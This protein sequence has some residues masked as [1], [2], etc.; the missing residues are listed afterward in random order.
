MTDNARVAQPSI[1]NLEVCG[2]ILKASEIPRYPL[3]KEAIFAPEDIFKRGMLAAAEG[4]GQMTEAVHSL[5][6]Q[7]SLGGWETDMD[8]D[9]VLKKRFA[10]RFQNLGCL[11]QGKEHGFTVVTAVVRAWRSSGNLLLTLSTSTPCG[12]HLNRE[13]NKPQGRGG[14]FTGERSSLMMVTWAIFHFIITSLLRP[15][16]DYIIIGEMTRLQPGPRSFMANLWGCYLY[17]VSSLM[18]TE[19]SETL[20]HLDRHRILICN[21]CLDNSTMVGRRLPTLDIIP[22]GWKPSPLWDGYFDSP[23]QTCCGSAGSIHQFRVGQW[24]IK[25]Q[26]GSWRTIVDWWSRQGIYILMMKGWSVTQAYDNPLL[27]KVRWLWEVHDDIKMLVR[28]PTVDLRDRLMGLTA[29]FT[30]LDGEISPQSRF[31]MQGE[32]IDLHL[33]LP[34]IRLV[35]QGY[36]DRHV[37]RAI[38]G[39]G[40][41]TL[42]LHK[43]MLDSNSPTSIRWFK[44]PLEILAQYGWPVCQLS[45]GTHLCAYC[46]EELGGLSA[47]ITFPR[48][49]NWQTCCKKCG[50]TTNLVLQWMATTPTTLKLVAMTSKLQ[51]SR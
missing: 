17:D 8:K 15:Q 27:I 40:P 6:P 48:E 49:G 3:T 29:G 37:M 32:A 50:T 21:I 33:L 4:I 22:A 44:E 1:Q 11:I 38:T 12:D 34:F 16:D 43:L 46:D 35:A 20:G 45:P 42:T 28:L 25:D 2:G 14:G 39:I 7:D 23:L 18:K 10:G 19:N 24:L 31:C 47:E 51:L 13:P 30:S 26:P 9:K 41:A 5:V 36:Q